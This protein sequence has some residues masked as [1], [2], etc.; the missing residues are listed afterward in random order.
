MRARNGRGLASAR[1]RRCVATRFG[2]SACTG[3]RRGTLVDNVGSQRVLE[4]NRFTR[5]GLAP[6]YLHIGGAL[7]RPRCS[8][9]ARSRTDER[10]VERYLLLGLRLGRHVDGLVDAYYGPPELAARSSRALGEEL[11]PTRGARREADAARG[12]LEPGAGWLGDQVR[13]LRT[14]AG[15]LAGESPPYADE[16]ERLLRRSARSRRRGRVRAGARAP[17]RAAPRRRARCPTLRGAG[18]R[19]DAVPAD[20][21]VPALARRRSACCASAPAR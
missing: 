20:L 12:E 2:S 5:I 19:A 13:G 17:R 18:A 3:S 6:H 7:A 4:R 16:V 21:I 15:V 1:W 11:A 14:Y 8:S 10:V 9:S